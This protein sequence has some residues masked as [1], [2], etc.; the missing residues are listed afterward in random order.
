MSTKGPKRKIAILSALVLLAAAFI[1]YSMNTP[2]ARAQKLMNSF[3]ASQYNAYMRETF[4]SKP[5]WGYRAL[6]AKN[7]PQI[8]DPNASLAEP[9]LAVRAIPKQ[10]SNTYYFEYFSST[11]GI[12]NISMIKTIA[13]IADIEVENK[14]YYLDGRSINTKIAKRYKAEIYFF[15]LETHSFIDHIGVDTAREFEK[16]MRKDEE[17]PPDEDILSAISQRLRIQT[18]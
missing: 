16:I 2:S 18:K 5:G 17:F 14:K 15:D 12:G 9:Y 4:L 13:V 10:N 1:V 3:K 7:F 6:R 11:K 8:H